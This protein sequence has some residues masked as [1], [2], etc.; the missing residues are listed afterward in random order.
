MTESQSNLTPPAQ[1]KGR[2]FVGRSR[3]M[4]SLLAA[5]RLC[6]WPVSPASA[7]PASPRTAPLC[8]GIGRQAALG[9]V[10][11][12]RGS[13]AVG[14]TVDLPESGAQVHDARVSGPEHEGSW[15]SASLRV[16]QPFPTVAPVGAAVGAV[17]GPGANHFRVVRVNHDAGHQRVCR[18]PVGQFLPLV[19]ARRQGVD[20]A[21]SAPA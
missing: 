16:V 1:P 17:L 3:E 14:A 10:L 2:A 15:R 12:R 8:R 20:A 7:R 11:R 18:Q 9:M 6:Y 19:G 21:F 5:A 4:K 13:T